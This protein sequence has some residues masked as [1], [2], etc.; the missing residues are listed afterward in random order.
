MVYIELLYRITNLLYKTV[1]P[2][3]RAIHSVSVL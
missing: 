2:K 1:A 3:L